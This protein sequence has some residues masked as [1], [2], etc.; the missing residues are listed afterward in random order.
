MCRILYGSKACKSGCPHGSTSDEQRDSAWY[1][2]QVL[3]PSLFLTDKST[4][5]AFREAPVQAD[6]S[7]SPAK[8]SR[9]EVERSLYNAWPCQDVWW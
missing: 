5:Q 2:R 1:V 3:Y 9:V 7:I 4:V 8:V 6:D